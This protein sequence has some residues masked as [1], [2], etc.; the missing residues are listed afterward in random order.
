MVVRCWYKHTVPVTAS[1]RESNDERESWESGKLTAMSLLH[2]SSCRH[3]KF[4]IPLPFTFQ[5]IINVIWKMSTNT[6]SVAANLL[7]AKC[8]GCS[9]LH[10]C[11]LAKVDKVKKVLFKCNP[12]RDYQLLAPTFAFCYVS[13]KRSQRWEHRHFFSAPSWLFFFKPGKVPN[14]IHPSFTL[15]FKHATFQLNWLIFN[16][17]NC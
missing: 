17:W 3:L 9:H 13:N 10:H 16:C 4:I 12:L 14:I 6:Y 1:K 11:F 7:S 8:R 5:W 15:L 2:W